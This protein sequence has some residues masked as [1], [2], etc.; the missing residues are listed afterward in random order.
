MADTAAKTDIVVVLRERIQHAVDDLPLEELY[1]TERYVSYLREM[2][3]DPVLR[4]YLEAPFD[5]E[6]VTPDEQE[7]IDRA[8]EDIRAGRVVSHE[9][10]R[11]RLLGK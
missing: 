4:A 2:A 9:K 3:L 11:R 5:D 7:A 8:Y 1:A 6:P 10:A